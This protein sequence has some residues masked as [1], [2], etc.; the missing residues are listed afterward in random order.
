MSAAQVIDHVGTLLSSY[1]AED[2]A[3]RARNT[4]RLG[5]LDADIAASQARI[6]AL[7]G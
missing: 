5:G 4:A 2:A 1:E 7:L 6:R 3:R